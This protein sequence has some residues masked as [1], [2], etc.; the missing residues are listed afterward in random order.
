M[1]GVER[2]TMKHLEAGTYLLHNGRLMKVIALCEYPTVLVQ[3][4]EPKD[5]PHCPSCGHELPPQTEHYV[6]DAL[7]WQEHVDAVPT[8]RVNKP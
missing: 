6:Q 3:P 1:S 7:N 8:V 4:V 2:I 5:F